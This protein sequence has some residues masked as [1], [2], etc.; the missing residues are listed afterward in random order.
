MDAIYLFA[1]SFVLIG[2]IIKLLKKAE[3]IFSE[4]VEKKDPELI[5]QI[6]DSG[7]NREQCNKPSA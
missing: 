6:M 3:S 5:L 1:F 4:P 2:F 7:I